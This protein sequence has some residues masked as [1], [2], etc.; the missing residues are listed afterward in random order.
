[1]NVQDNIRI[2]RAALEAFEAHD[3]DRFVSFM[4]ESVL[5]YVPGR[6]EPLRGR[7]AVREDNI[8]FLAMYP[9][10]TFEITQ[11][12]GNGDMVCAQGIVKGTNTGPLPGPDGKQLPPTNKSFRV[13]A[14]F[15]AKIENGKIS[16]IYEYLDRLE[17]STQLG[18]TA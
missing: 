4:S 16:E 6:S 18:N 13:P 9:D 8:G 1:M 2:T 12:F 17:F 14:C 10:V 5:D 15:V 7:E 3:M 11:I